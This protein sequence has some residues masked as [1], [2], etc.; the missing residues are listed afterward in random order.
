MSSPPVEPD[1]VNPDQTLRRSFVFLLIGLQVLLAA[2]VIAG[3]LQYASMMRN[4]ALNERLNHVVRNV[5]G[6]EEHLTQTF[7]LVGLTLANLE[8]LSGYRPG[9]AARQTQARLEQIQRQMPVLRSLSL[10]NRQGRIVASSVA[11]NLGRKLDLSVLLP[12]VPVEQ[13]GLLRFGLPWEGRDFADGRPTQPAAPADLRSMGFIPLALTLPGDSGLVAVAAVN[14]DFFLN[15]IVGNFD[16]ELLNVSVLDYNG[17]LLL[18]NE[19]DLAPGARPVEPTLLEHIKQEEIGQQ[20]TTQMHGSEAL[21]AYRAS[22]NYPLFVFGYADHE[23]VLAQ[24]RADMLVTFVL[25]G[26]TLLATLL[27][28]GILTQRLLATLVRE[29][30]L[31]EAQR[32][33][34]RVFQNSNDGIIITGPDTKILSVNPAFQRISGY[35]AEELV[36]QKPQ[37][38]ASGQ[39]PPEFYARMWQA[40]DEQGDWRGEI[41]NRRKDGSLVAEWVSITRMRDTEGK[42]SGYLGFFLDLSELR[43]SEQL[44]RQLSTAVEQSPSSIVITNLNAVIEYVNPQFTRATGYT[45]NEAVGRNPSFLQSKRTAPETF[46]ALWERLF[47][48]ESWEGEFINQRKDGSI[49]YDNAKLAPIRDGSGRI[50]NYLAVQH[51]ITARKEA[52][53]ALIKAKDA[54]E[55][56][57]RA[58]TAFLANMSHE[59]RTPMNGVMGMLEIARRYMTDPQ[60]LDKLDKAK[61]SAERLLGVLN[62]ILDIAKIEADHMV[63]ENHP[64]QLA[65]SVENVVGTIGHKAAE[66]GLALVADL[67]AG[68][69]KLPLTGDPLRFGQILFNL[70]GNAIKFTEQG[71]VLLRARVL[72]ENAETMQVR[73]EVIDTGI[74]IDAEAQGRLFQPFEQADN[75]MTRKYGGTGLGLAICKRLVQLM[76]GE[77]GVDS[78]M[79]TGSTFWFVVSLNKRDPGVAAP[80][81]AFTH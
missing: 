2:V 34:A 60:G 75:S 26:L 38:L 23:Q 10:A 77:I 21:L 41:A 53:T 73:F 42:T 70:I 44:V 54:A 66:K 69:A 39:Q 55:A 20:R 6:V 47:A 48:G 51:D 37:F 40:L 43:R 59:L 18:S 11:A 76:G 64:F 62:D 31:Q 14:A 57:S 15:R 12:Q 30:R 1:A 46:S 7:Y 50:T 67:P 81:T 28:T 16:R 33:A 29:G 72:A 61:L 19:D 13:A 49:Y 52:E 9:Q 24:W 63:L 35:R 80:A 8:E 32:L 65:D 74:G 25:A 17:I 36:G 68:L 79:G 4:N 58:K 71:E 5:Q 78:R 56:A 27:I 45:P 3:T 22:R